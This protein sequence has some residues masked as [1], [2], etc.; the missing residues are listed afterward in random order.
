[1]HDIKGNTWYWEVEYAR[2]TLKLNNQKDILKKVQIFN[3]SYIQYYMLSDR[4]R[5]KVFYNNISI[6][7]LLLVDIQKYILNIFKIS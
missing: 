5:E 1:M 3:D 2:N 7:I 6:Y 4:E